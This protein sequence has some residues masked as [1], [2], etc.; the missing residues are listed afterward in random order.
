MGIR[1]IGLENQARI[2]ELWSTAKDGGWRT[3]HPG[4]AKIT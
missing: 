1:K 4:G 3:F 2:S